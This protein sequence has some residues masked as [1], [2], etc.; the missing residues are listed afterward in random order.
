M[1]IG[2]RDICR[3]SHFLSNLDCSNKLETFS[4]C[5]PKLKHSPAHFNF[6]NGLDIYLTPDMS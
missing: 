4:N 1:M 6:R 2:E 3:F 5:L